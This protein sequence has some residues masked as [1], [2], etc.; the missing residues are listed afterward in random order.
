[1]IQDLFR[2]IYR[3]LLLY[4]AALV[5]KDYEQNPDKY[6]VDE[7]IERYIDDLIKEKEEAV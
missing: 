6:L 7:D 5:I 1:M 4:K 2:E 3:M